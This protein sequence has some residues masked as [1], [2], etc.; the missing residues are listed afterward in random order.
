MACHALT[1]LCL[2]GRLGNMRMDCARAVLAFLKAEKG[3]LPSVPELRLLAS[4]LDEAPVD[5][6]HVHQWFHRNYQ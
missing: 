6:A 3:Q 1:W 2:T 5:A 4:L